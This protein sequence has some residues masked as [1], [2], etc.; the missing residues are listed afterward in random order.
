MLYD[1]IVQTVKDSE[2]K[3]TNCIYL[4]SSAERA[5]NKYQNKFRNLSLNLIL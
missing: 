4:F 2:T 3:E 1:D 5:F